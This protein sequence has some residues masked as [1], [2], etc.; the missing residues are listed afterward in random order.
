MA[1]QGWSIA[2]VSR[3]FTISHSTARQWLQPERYAAWKARNSEYQRTHAA[4]VNELAKLRRPLMTDKER[5]RRAALMRRRYR[6]VPGVKSKLKELRDKYALTAQ[7]CIALRMRHMVLG[8]S[9]RFACIHASLMQAITSCTREQFTKHFEGDGVFDHIVPL[10]AFD[11]T[12]PE[13]VIRANHP[14]NLRLVPAKVNNRK[15]AKHD[16][17]DVMALQWSGNPDA[18]VQ[19]QAFISRQLSN[20]ARRQEA[21]GRDPAEVPQTVEMGENE[22]LGAIS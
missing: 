15:H 19:A 1:G 16:C 13:H 2:D 18:I 7:F 6:E 8:W 22:F 9:N 14:S 5:N 12:N 4:R 11:L 20:L 17:L 10:A 3:H 21:A